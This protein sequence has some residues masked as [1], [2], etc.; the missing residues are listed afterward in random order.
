MHRRRI[1]FILQKN[2]KSYNVGRHRC[3]QKNSTIMSLYGNDVE[4]GNES[5]DF[6]QS[7]TKTAKRLGLSIVITQVRIWAMFI[8]CFVHSS[9]SILDFLRGVKAALSVQPSVF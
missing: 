7:S 5:V 2:S 1:F 8:L 3:L 4:K 6:N 9:W